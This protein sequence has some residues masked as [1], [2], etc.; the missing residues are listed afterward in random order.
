MLLS[1][2]SWL[3]TRR[4]N[5]SIQ[6]FSVASPSSCLFTCSSVAFTFASYSSARD[7]HSVRLFWRPVSMGV[8][9]LWNRESSC[10]E[11]GW[12]TT[13][14]LRPTLSTCRLRGS[15]RKL[16]CSEPRGWAPRAAPSLERRALSCR[17]TRLFNLLSSELFN[18]TPE[19]EGGSASNYFGEK[20]T[21]ASHVGP[22][23]IWLQFE[24]KILIQMIMCFTQSIC[25]LT[26]YTKVQ[27]KSIN[28][29]WSLG[30]SSFL[31]LSIIG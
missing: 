10:R 14:T 6:P 21:T 12:R 31:F 19:W 28:P 7:F 30:S 11:S 16:G 20:R 5:N 26:L 24:R 17:L 3:P 9:S 13:H 2:D 27:T 18:S 29:T 15:W 8:T 23:W 4:K 1:C 25:L 22:L